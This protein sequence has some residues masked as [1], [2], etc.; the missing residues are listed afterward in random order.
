MV[1]VAVHTRTH[2]YLLLL[3]P[4]NNSILKCMLSFLGDIPYWIVQNSWGTTWGDGGYVYIK[5]GSNVCGKYYICLLLFSVYISFQLW[6]LYFKELMCPS[7]YFLGIADSVAAVFLWQTV[8]FSF[9]LYICVSDCVRLCSLL[10]RF[11]AVICW[12]LTITLNNCIEI[13]PSSIT[14]TK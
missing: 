2:T 12:P 14:K 9:S 5:I 8:Y 4:V 10:E 11:K 6:C 3:Y 7:F 1:A 13:S